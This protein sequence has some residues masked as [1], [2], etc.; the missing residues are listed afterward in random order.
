MDR[1]EYGREQ[2][3]P[4][5]RDR[6]QRSWRPGDYDHDPEQFEDGYGRIQSRD[7]EGGRYP[8]AYGEGSA[9]GGGSTPVGAGTYGDGGPYR[10]GDPASTRRGQ[11]ERWQG[12]TYFGDSFDNR[13]RPGGDRYG[14]RSGRYSGMGPKG[15]QRSDDRICEEVCE[16]LTR[17]GSVD[18]SEVE[19]SVQGGEVYLSG[20]VMDRRQKR[21]AEEAAECVSGVRDV[22]N[23][24]RVGAQQ[25]TNGM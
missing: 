6:E 23:Q 9:F 1:R 2:G 12:E 13:E 5:Y 16:Y 20:S 21:A 7:Y 22:H 10:G 3:G 14:T 25:A 19:V 24:L 15:Y 4:A 11:L 8:G 17:D 18:A